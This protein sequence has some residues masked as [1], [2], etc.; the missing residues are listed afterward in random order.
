[1]SGTREPGLGSPPAVLAPDP[2]VPQRDRLTDLDA[3]TRLLSARLGRGGPVAI[4]SCRLGRVSYR[5]GRRVRAV[6]QLGIDGTEVHVAASTFRSRGRAE[7][8][9]RQALEA[10]TDAGLCSGPFRPA[11]F[12]AGLDTVFRTLPNDRRIGHLYAVLDPPDDLAGLAGLVDLSDLTTGR[13]ASSRLV[14]YNPEIS[15]VVRCLDGSGRAIG[16]AKVHAGDEGERA[17]RVQW[18]LARLAEGS[19]PRV[20]RP[21]AYAARYRT[22][23]VEPITGTSIRFLTGSA[24]LAGLHAYGAALAGLHR[25][26]PDGLGTG[27]RDALERLRHRADGVRM[28]R[29]DAAEQVGTLLRELGARWGQ[30][31]EPGVPIHGDANESNAILQGNGGAGGDRIALIDFDRACLGQAGTDVGNFLSLL[32]YFRALGHISPREESARAAAFERGYASVRPLPR[33][34]ALR[35]HESAAL[36]ERAFRSVTRLRRSAL[37]RLPALLAESRELLR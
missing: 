20:A 9:Y 27:G 7:R 19:D 28:V 17:Y 37:V 26:P 1:M 24:L 15:A 34:D 11:V 36:A 22:L 6:Y 12:D 13:W 29:P 5:P 4:R 32:R 23:L 31:P 35:V 21:L 3:I 30:A 2:A 18:T 10:A 33:R 14:D 16:Y 25:L 8:A